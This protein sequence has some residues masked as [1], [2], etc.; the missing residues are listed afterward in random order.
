L[1]RKRSQKR[2]VVVEDCSVRPAQEALASAIR[3]RHES[4]LAPVRGAFGVFY[5]RP[6][7]PGE[8]APGAAGGGISPELPFYADSVTVP[9]ARVRIG[10]VITYSRSGLGPPVGIRALQVAVRAAVPGAIEAVALPEDEYDAWALALLGPGLSPF[11]YRYRM[12]RP[13]P[14]GSVFYPVLFDAAGRPVLAPRG[15]DWTRFALGGVPDPAW[16]GRLTA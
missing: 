4:V 13:Q 10:V 7:K 9:S 11:A 15:F 16:I 14:S 12:W 3:R 8:T 6:L 2:G 5:R 1:R